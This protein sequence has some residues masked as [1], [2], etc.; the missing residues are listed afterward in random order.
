MQKPRRQ[1]PSDDKVRTYSMQIIN[2]TQRLEE[3]LHFMVAVLIYF[4]GGRG[5]SSPLQSAWC[6][7]G[8][9]RG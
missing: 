2:H 7:Q 4:A 5:W 3:L 6:D 9:N 8:R 1:Q